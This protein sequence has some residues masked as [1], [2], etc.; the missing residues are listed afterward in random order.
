MPFGATN[1]PGSLD[2][3][4]SLGSLVNNCATTLAASYTSGATSIAVTDGSAFPSTGGAIFVGGERTVY[5]ARSGNTLTIAALSNNYL[6]G[7]AVELRYDAAN[8][9]VLR[10]A[11]VALEARLGVTGDTTPGTM[12]KRIA[13]LEA[14]DAAATARAVRRG[15]LYAAQ[16]LT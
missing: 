8:H 1:F 15:R 6:A 4:A 3:A 9:N 14:N 2:D 13:D 10:A 12:T 16:N 11:I 5:S 7:A